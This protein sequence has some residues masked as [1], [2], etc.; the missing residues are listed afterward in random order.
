MNSKQNVVFFFGLTLLILVF[1]VNGYWSILHAGIFPTNPYAPNPS[2]GNNF[3][4]AKNGKCP[5]GY[6]NFNGYC[7]PPLNPNIVYG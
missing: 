3:A 5:A 7:I 2:G 4:K 6:K 1:W